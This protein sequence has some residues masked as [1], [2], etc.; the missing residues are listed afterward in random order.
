MLCALFLSASRPEPQARLPV[1]R[2]DPAW[3]ARFPVSIDR[4]TE[5]LRQLPLP[6]PQP[7]E[8]PRGS[9]KLTWLHRH[10]ELT[11]PAPDAPDQMARLFHSLA[12]AAPG[13]AVHYN[14][15]SNGAQVQIG[16]DGLL[17]HSLT[18]YWLGHRPRVAIVLGDLGGDL[19]IAREIVGMSIPLTLAVQPFLPFSRQ[20]AE[21]AKLFNRELLVQVD[22]SFPPSGVSAGDSP[23]T[24]MGREPVADRL[25]AA[26]AEIPHALGIVPTGSVLAATPPQI[27]TAYQWMS[28]HGLAVIHLRTETTASACAIADELHLRCAGT[29]IVLDDASHPQDVSLQVDSMI[30]LIR[31]RGDIIAASRATPTALDALRAA[32]PR[33]SSTG[34]EVVPLS[35]LLADRSFTRR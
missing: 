35:T 10:Y 24:R 18:L 30:T 19:R 15:N 23:S 34:I 4:V 25:E 12:D 2:P 27:R 1:P 28:A 17:T 7:I 32:L 16:I 8:A 14:P 22:D 13:V 33:L 9:G 5:A 3:A 20:V 11:M 21:L 26:T 6:L 29:D 31:T